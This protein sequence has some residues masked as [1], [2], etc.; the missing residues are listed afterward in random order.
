VFGDCRLQMVDGCYELVI[1]DAISVKILEPRKTA[2]LEFVSSPRNDIMA[3]E[4]G[5]LLSQVPNDPEWDPFGGDVESDRITS[6]LQI[7]MSEYPESLHDG[8]TI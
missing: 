3:D 4:F 1:K 6:I 7:V 2:C 5:F 8:H